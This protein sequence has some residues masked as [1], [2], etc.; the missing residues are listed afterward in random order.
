MRKLISV[1]LTI[2]LLCPG[3]ATGKAAGEYAENVL[4]QHWL[5]TLGYLDGVPTGT[6]DERTTQAIESFQQERG[7]QV[8]GEINEQTRF[9]LRTMATP[10]QSIIHRVKERESMWDISRMYG[11][12]V[13]ALAEINGIKNPSLIRIGQELVIPANIP[14]DSDQI[15]LATFEELHSLIPHGSTFVLVD[16]QRELAVNL[17]RYHGHFHIDAEPLTAEDTETLK[18]I[19]DGKW[20]DYPRP[21]WLLID[22]KRYAV[23]YSG[24]PRGS[25][26]IYDNGFAGHLCIHP[27]G[28]KSHATGA[29]DQGFQRAVLRACGYEVP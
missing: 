14:V 3:G 9:L 20:E 4:V 5:I 27:L 18:D 12:T 8:S 2:F 15:L 24:F 23:G 17:V 28:G 16:A 1:I 6:I 21:G 29:I 22:G 19:Y 11:M 7:L 25:F 26:S 10:G 13:A